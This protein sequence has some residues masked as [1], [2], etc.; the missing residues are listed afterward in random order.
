MKYLIKYNFNK[1]LIKND[2]DLYIYDFG[3]LKGFL[4]NNIFN[5]YKII[6]KNKESEYVEDYEGYIPKD[7]ISIEKYKC[8]YDN[9]TYITESF[10][11][12]IQQQDP[13]FDVDQPLLSFPVEAQKLNYKAKEHKVKQPFVPND[14]KK[15]KKQ[16]DFHQQDTGDFPNHSNSWISLDQI[17][18][19]D[20]KHHPQFSSKVKDFHYLKDYKKFS[21]V[22]QHQKRF[23][24]DHQT[25]LPLDDFLQDLNSKPSPTV[26]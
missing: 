8:N 20:S 4:Y 1:N 24:K 21:Q 2:F 11:I 12:I 17:V 19:N 15:N 10:T 14:L 5:L 3:Y 18:L 23:S 22:R 6:K 13:E 7:V 16:G 9:N 26:D 25:S